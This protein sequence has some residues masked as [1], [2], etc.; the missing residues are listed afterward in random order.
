MMDR[1]KIDPA[2][3]DPKR[4]R[5]LDEIVARVKDRMARGERFTLPLAARNT[6]ANEAP[7]PTRQIAYGP[8]IDSG[9]PSTTVGAVRAAIANGERD[10]TEIMVLTGCTDRSVIYNE[11]AKWR[12]Q[13]GE[14]KPHRDCGSERIRQALRGGLVEIDDIMRAASI[15]CRNHVAKVR[16]EWRAKQQEEAWRTKP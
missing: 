7:A 2:D 10:V 15:D 13:T 1:F 11:L 5:A 16:R 9:V 3:I 14:P 6:P 12:A 8:P 4:A